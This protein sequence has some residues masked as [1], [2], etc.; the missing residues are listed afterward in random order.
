M[1]PSAVNP[2]DPA[3]RQEVRLVG[4]ATRTRWGAY[5]LAQPGGPPGPKGVYYPQNQTTNLK[6]R[7]DPPPPAAA[8]TLNKCSDGRCNSGMGGRR[9][10]EHNHHRMNRMARPWAP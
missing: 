3:T 6:P 7:G 4:P 1:A 2:G 5:H 8:P 9:K 10:E